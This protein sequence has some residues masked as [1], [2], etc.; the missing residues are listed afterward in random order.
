M[1]IEQR[2]IFQKSV[3]IQ[4]RDRYSPRFHLF[5]PFLLLRQL[6][7]LEPE[8]QESEA[9]REEYEKGEEIAAEVR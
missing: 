3:F 7:E 9:G 5:P 6:W 4:R 1:N 2:N 8:G